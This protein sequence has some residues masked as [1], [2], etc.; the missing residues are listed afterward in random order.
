MIISRI[1]ALFASLTFLLAGA[2]ALADSHVAHLLETPSTCGDAVARVVNPHHPL[3]GTRIFGEPSNA[4]FEVTGIDGQTAS[5]YSFVTNKCDDSLVWVVAGTQT[6][7]DGPGVW[8]VTTTGCHEGDG[9]VHR[10]L[11]NGFEQIIDDIT[12]FIDPFLAPN[13][14]DTFTAIF[15]G[16]SSELGPN[17]SLV[18]QFRLPGTVTGVDLHGSST[19]SLCEREQPSTTGKS[20]N[21]IRH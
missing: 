5:T 3:I 1:P 7:P 2:P 16:Q 6:G 14:A 21:V 18:G 11:G 8:R 13:H 10:S 15:V 17:T 20:V 19:N 12:S 9:V 4:G